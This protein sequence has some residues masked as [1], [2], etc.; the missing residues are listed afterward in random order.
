MYPK[1]FVDIAA[2]LGPDNPNA[3]AALNVL[4]QILA[5]VPGGGRPAIGAARQAFL[6]STPS[7]QFDQ[8]RW[9]IARQIL[10]MLS[11]QQ[12]GWWGYKSADLNKDC[13]VNMIDLPIIGEQW[14]ACTNPN[15]PCDCVELN[16]LLSQFSDD[17]NTLALYHLNQS[18]GTVVLDDNGS[19]RTV[20]NGTINGPPSPVWSSGLFGNCLQNSSS[21]Y[22]GT[23]VSLS[24]KCSALI[25]VITSRCSC[26]LG[27]TR[28]RQT[29]SIT[30]KVGSMIGCMAPPWGAGLSG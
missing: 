14:F 11:T 21:G 30:R 12:C 23:L 22:C 27:L 1:T 17:S 15:D 9:D 19:G 8:F 7:I 18:S 6:D 10:K 2:K 24:M 28:D 4:N 29:V 26:S 20:H 13:I 5:P 25:P 3:L 16:N